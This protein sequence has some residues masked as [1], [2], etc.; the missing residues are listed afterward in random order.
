MRLLL[1]LILLPFLGVSQQLDTAF[2]FTYGG[3][4]EDQL[5]KL[6][7]TSD[8]GFVMVGSTSSFGNGNTDIYIVKT[9]SLANLQWSKVIGKSGIDIGRSVIESYDKGLIITGITNSSGAGGYEVLLVKTD[10]AGNVLWENTFGGVDWDFGISVVELPDKS[11]VIAG[12]THS[13]GNG[14]T[15]IYLLKTDSEGNLIWSKTYG[16]DKDEET[17]S[18]ILTNDNNLL[19]VGSTES[20]GLEGKDAYILKVNFNGDTLWTTTFGG[21]KDDSA[22]AVANAIDNGYIITG[23]SA[24]FTQGGDKDILIFKLTKDGTFL[25]YYT[26]GENPAKENKDDEGKGIFVRSDGSFLLTG[27]T[28]TNG[29]GFKDV[30]GFGTDTN[31]WEDL[32]ESAS[33]GGIYDEEGLDIIQ[34]KNNRYVIGGYTSSYGSGKTDFMLIF[35]K[36][37]TPGP[38]QK[39]IVYGDTITVSIKPELAVK[40]DFKVHPVPSKGNVFIDGNFIGNKSSLKLIDF[41]GRVIYNNIQPENGRFVIEKR[42]LPTGLYFF[43]ILTLTE[44]ISGKIIFID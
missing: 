22:F 10:S 7:E 21:I 44:N 35:M 5:Y 32:N 14:G 28:A 41:S 17:S 16:G 23:G 30:F 36:K 18:L 13:F 43:Q 3:K 19:I 24:S 31:G 20:F 1:I 38:F 6:I 2:I 27:Y 29:L 11:I 9:D 26:L 34:T 37:I 12:H 33:Y 40:P 42:Q 15:D 8:S 25:W 39:V 4:G